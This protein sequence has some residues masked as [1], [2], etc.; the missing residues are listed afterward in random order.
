MLS[1]LC[2]SGMMRF[3]GYCV[4]E[5][6]SGNAPLDLARQPYKLRDTTDIGLHAKDSKTGV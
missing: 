5:W 3:P 2:L 4:W 6:G 1:R